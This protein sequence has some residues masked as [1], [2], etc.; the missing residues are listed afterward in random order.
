MMKSNDRNLGLAI[1][2]LTIGAFSFRCHYDM[3]IRNQ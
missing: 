1:L 3:I 2:A